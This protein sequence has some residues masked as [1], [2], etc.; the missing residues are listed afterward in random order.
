MSEPLPVLV[1]DGHPQSREALCNLI[2]QWGFEC[3]TAEDGPNGVETALFWRPGVVVAALD[4]PVF[5]GLELA[6][7]VRAAL[8][9]NV[10]LV[11]LTVFDGEG[12]SRRAIQAGFDHFL[13]KPADLGELR[14]LL[15]GQAALLPC[16]VAGGR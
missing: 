13:V 14:R 10:R 6:R 5:N 8:G 3:R 2:E 1:V 12:T 15:G 7:R 9:R 16:Q 4:L 11:A